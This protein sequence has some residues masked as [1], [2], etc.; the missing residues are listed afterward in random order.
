MVGGVTGWK[1]Y[2]KCRF[3]VLGN[4]KRCFLSERSLALP[5]CPRE[6]RG[7]RRVSRRLAKLFTIDRRLA[8][9]MK[10]LHYL[11]T[12]LIQASSIVHLLLH[13]SAENDI[14]VFILELAVLNKQLLIYHISALPSDDA[15]MP[16]VIRE[17]W[18]AVN[19]RSD[20]PPTKKNEM[21][22]KD[23]KKG[24]QYIIKLPLMPFE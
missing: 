12:F 9:F 3:Y 13:W 11:F 7:R 8:K 16:T 4:G 17:S 20:V 23:E 2:W 18:R 5:G 21:K 14:D 10:Y 15:V 6:V 24:F 19:D 22:R 1:L